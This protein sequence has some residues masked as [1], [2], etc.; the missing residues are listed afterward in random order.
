MVIKPVSRRHKLFLGVTCNEFSILF[1]FVFGSIYIR[2]NVIPGGSCGYIHQSCSQQQHQN[3]SLYK[4]KTTLMNQMR[5]T[6]RWWYFWSK[7]CLHF[8]ILICMIQHQ[9]QHR[10]HHNCF[11][12]HFLCHLPLL[13]CSIQMLGKCLHNFIWKFHYPFVPNTTFYFVKVITNK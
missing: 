7:H 1:A 2:Y 5:S 4:D 6:M 9:I 10:H 11:Q 8:L 3:Q 12:I 13:I